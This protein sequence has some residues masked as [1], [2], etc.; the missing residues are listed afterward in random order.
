VYQQQLL[1]GAALQGPAGETG[2]A[3]AASSS[4]CC[5]FSFLPDEGE[6]FRSGRKGRSLSLSTCIIIEVQGWAP[7][8]SIFF[9]FATQ[10]DK[11]QQSNK[12]W[13][14]LLLGQSV[15]AVMCHPHAVSID[16]H[17]SKVKPGITT[18]MT[19]TVHHHPVRKPQN[20]IIQT[21]QTAVNHKENP[22]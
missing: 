14:A 7:V 12:P 17:Q 2:G 3:A 4:C 18:S 6:G 16:P 21:K 8:Q 22:E 5:L 19:V 15:H 11:R 10:K 9:S 20:A 13:Q 1:V